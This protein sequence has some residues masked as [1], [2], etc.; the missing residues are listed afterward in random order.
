MSDG[1]TRW[2]MAAVFV[3]IAGTRVVAPDACVGDIYLP[4]HVPGQVVS[5]SEGDA[6]SQAHSDSQPGPS[7][8]GPL[9][10]L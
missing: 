9:P 1:V 2:P 7:A 10:T 8:L 5:P 6:T 3:E 4:E